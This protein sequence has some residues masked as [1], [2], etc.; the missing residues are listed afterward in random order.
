MRT[1]TRRE[2]VTAATGIMLL[3]PE[4]VFGAEANSSVSFGI[5][6]TG[7]RGQYVGGHM[8]RDGRTRVAA[9]V[10]KDYRQ[11]WGAWLTSSTARSPGRKCCGP[12][13]RDGAPRR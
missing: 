3:Q 10:Y 11:P 1:I 6:G 4:T 13:S 7:A 8:A 2:A 5:I 12:G 9:K